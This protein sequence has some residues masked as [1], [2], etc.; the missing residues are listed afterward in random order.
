MHFGQVSAEVFCSRCPPWT[1][2]GWFHPP[3]LRRHTC[4]P[5]PCPYL[6]TWSV[7]PYFITWP[8]TD[9]PRRQH[10]NLPKDSFHC[11]SPVT[12]DSW[13]WT[14]TWSVYVDE[15]VNTCKHPP[16]SLLNCPEW[17]QIRVVTVDTPLHDIMTKQNKTTRRFQI[18]YIFISLISFEKKNN[19][20]KLHTDSIYV[21]NMNSM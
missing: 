10:L 1:L 21:G 19:V 9:S 4:P 16:L 15:N 14:L 8:I 3:T 2:V 7:F 6:V 17:L 13:V 18:L 12:A 11:A 5:R 20:I